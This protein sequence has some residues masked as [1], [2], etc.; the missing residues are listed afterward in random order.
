VTHP[1]GLGVSC[2]GN[3][4]HAKAASDPRTRDKEKPRP[5]NGDEARRI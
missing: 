1:L 3:K 5:L 4:Y 2:R